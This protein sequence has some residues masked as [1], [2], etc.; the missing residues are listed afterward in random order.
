MMKNRTDWIK[1][2]KNGWHLAVLA[3]SVLV[4]SVLCVR[5]AAEKVTDWM[6][7]G[8]EIEATD[9]AVQTNDVFLTE[10]DGVPENEK[11]D[12]ERR[13][14]SSVNNLLQK[15]DRL[16]GHI[17]RLWDRS[18]Y[19]KAEMSRLDSVLTYLSTGEIASGQIICGSEGWMFYKSPNDGNS[20]ADYEGTNRYSNRELDSMLKAVMK[21]Q[22]EAEKRGMRFAVLVLPN[23]ENIYSE[24][25]PKQYRHEPISSTDLLIDHLKSE[26]A[27]VYS[28]KEEMLDCHNEM[29]LYYRY[30]SHWNQLGGY[31]GLK[32]VLNDWGISLP[33]LSEREVISR[34]LK[35]CRHDSA[36]DDLARMA[37]LLRFFDDE[38]EYAVAGTLQPDWAAYDKEQSQG[39]LSKYHNEDAKTDKTV[40]LVGDSYRTALIPA[41]CESF[42]EVG[43]IHRSSYQSWML[44]AF[45]PDFLLT[46][47]VERYSSEIAEIEFL[48]KSEE[49]EKTGSD[50]A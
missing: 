47:Y 12:S 2:I 4:F 29:Q 35:D 39:I 27:Y 28:P 7:T 16:V 24:Y 23:K 10:R 8:N 36:N 6:S 22:K 31:I 25:M 13:E 38:M 44:D 40:M 48:F 37:G 17:E 9:T 41:L 34:L 3:I 1:Q 30:D 26:G 42:R 11:T 33:A 18:I 32:T 14:T 45:R 21:T 19:K 5:T 43:V 15:T 49:R 46:E 20:M 50:T